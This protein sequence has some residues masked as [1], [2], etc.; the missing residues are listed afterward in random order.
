MI[1]ICPNDKT[2]DKFTTTAHV[3]EEWRVDKHGD[4]IEVTQSLETTHA[5]DHGNIWFCDVCGE[6]ALHM[7][8]EPEPKPRTIEDLLDFKAIFH[9]V[10][11]RILSESDVAKERWLAAVQVVAPIGSAVKVDA[12]NSADEFTQAR[13]GQ[14]GS[15]EGYDAA[16]RQC[17]YPLICVLF[18]DG[19]HEAF[20]DD[21]LIPITKEN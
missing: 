10:Q 7:E 19:T 6:E 4:F 20:Y 17:A 18:P 8:K 14:V 13:G 2:H 3:V 5:P 9:E 15:V 12:T 11:E 21:E 16:V 1:A